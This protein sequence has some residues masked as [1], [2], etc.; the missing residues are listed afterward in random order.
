M[1]A[2]VDALSSR[3]KLIIDP[4]VLHRSVPVS[5]A[6]SISTVVDAVHI[7]LSCFSRGFVLHA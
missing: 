6:I 2:V 4:S 7:C 1:A 5:A 3:S